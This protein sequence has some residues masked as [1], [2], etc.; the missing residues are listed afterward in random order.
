[1]KKKRVT[2]KSAGLGSRLKKAVKNVFKKASPGKK[3][4]SPSKSSELPAKPVRKNGSKPPIGRSTTTWGRNRLYVSLNRK[5]KTGSQKAEPPS[6]LPFSYNKTLL[7]LLVRDPEWAYAYW[8]FSSE[9]WKW[10]QSLYKK[11]S[12]LAA[13]IR[14]Y[15]L[16]TGSSFDFEVNL[17]AKNWYLCL[18][19][20]NTEF[21]AELG[22]MDRSGKF[23]VIAR[24]N[25]IKTPRNHPSDQI[26]PNWIP[27]NF[28]ELYG[29]SGGGRAGESSS[30]LLTKKPSS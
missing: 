2:T 25:R 19:L 23:Y 3:K 29:L 16:S 9:T 30:H 21:E 20:P 15:N 11:Y 28:D 7:T 22:L 14:I 8:D 6:D 26:D 18:G 4:N 5:S 24:S 27:E 10:I 12:G 1:M 17:E 13:K